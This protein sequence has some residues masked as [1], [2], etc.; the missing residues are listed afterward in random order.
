MKYLEL[1]SKYDTEHWK[2]VPVLNLSFDSLKF[3]NRYFF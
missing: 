1:N 2:N 3:E